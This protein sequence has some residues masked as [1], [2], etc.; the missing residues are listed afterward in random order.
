MSE[1]QNNKFMKHKNIFFQFDP[2]HDDETMQ[3][4]IKNKLETKLTH[5]S[6]LYKRV[7]RGCAIKGK[8]II[9]ANKMT[10]S[11]ALLCIWQ[12]LLCDA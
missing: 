6:F 10:I 1:N 9:I 4:L 2:T 8:K 7:M 12:I 3:E 5:I 11:D